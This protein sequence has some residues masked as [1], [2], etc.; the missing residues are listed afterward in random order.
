MAF[1]PITAGGESFGELLTGLMEKY[2]VRAVEIC[3]KTGI[4][5]SYFSKL[6]NGSL[7]PS[8][9]KMIREIADV[10]GAD[11]DE[12]QTLCDILC[13]HRLTDSHKSIIGS[14]K[15]VYSL[16]EPEICEFSAKA[17][18]SG[19]LIEGIDDV[20]SAVRTVISDSVTHINMLLFADNPKLY[21][22]VEQALSGKGEGFDCRWLLYLEENNELSQYNVSVFSELIPIMMSKCVEV[23]YKTADTAPLRENVLFPY[24]FAGDNGLLLVNGDCTGAVY[25]DDA[26]TVKRYSDE[27]YGQYSNCGE[28]CRMFDDITG[29]IRDNG[30]I[31]TDNDESESTEVYI[32]KRL[33]CIMMEVNEDV[34]TDHFRDE[35]IKA[36]FVKLFME[37]LYRQNI[38][39]ISRQNF[40]FAPQGI[41]ELLEADVYYE[42]NESIDYPVSKELRRKFFGKFIDIARMS[43]AIQANAFDEFFPAESR[44]CMNIWTNGKLLIFMNF[45]PR[46]RIFVLNEKSVTA[47]ILNTFKELKAMRYILPKKRTLEMMSEGLGE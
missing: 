17:F 13:R 25:L 21:K 19:Q 1:K 31:L 32:L 37:F 2:G 42:Y 8:D 24:A 12:V 9:C 7:L 44:H 33:P 15:S 45:G 30:K 28:L 34:V 39:G 20:C 46:Y 36:D 6:K 14:L 41:N 18:C 29:F 16:K 26:E 40:I 22:A 5:K 47:P 4:K 23:H 10:L 43:E 11:K 3:S 27:I 35:G 38:H